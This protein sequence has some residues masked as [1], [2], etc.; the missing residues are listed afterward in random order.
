MNFVRNMDFEMFWLKVPW[1]P[2][3]KMLS[4]LDQFWNF[5][6]SMSFIPVIWTLHRFCA[7][8]TTFCHFWCRL[9]RSMSLSSWIQ[10]LNF[11]EDW[12]IW[13]QFSWKLLMWIIR[14]KSQKNQRRYL[15]R[16]L[17]HTVWSCKKSKPLKLIKMINLTPSRP[18]SSFLCPKP[19]SNSSPTSVSATQTS[20]TKTT[21]GTTTTLTKSG[22]T[23]LLQPKRSSV[24][25][26]RSPTS[27]TLSPMST[28]MPSSARSTT[29]G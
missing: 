1:F 7:R 24:W 23:R 28:Q 16:L 9:G 27:L 13:R 18:S 26:K 22:K 17:T 29:T 3:L 12:M 25:P 21:P 2:C 11:W 10:Y 5:Q 19:T 4:D 8:L 15:K 20:R 14:M 6:R